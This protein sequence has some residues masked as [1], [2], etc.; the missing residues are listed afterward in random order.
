MAPDKQ[1]DERDIISQWLRDN[2][3]SHMT[4]DPIEMSWLMEDHTMQKEIWIMNECHITTNL[5]NS[6]GNPPPTIP[7]TATKPPHPLPEE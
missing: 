5:I 4:R 1:T 6:I 3:N 7:T 2:Y